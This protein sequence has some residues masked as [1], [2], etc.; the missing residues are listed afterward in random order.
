[1]TTTQGECFV[2]VELVGDERLEGVLGAGE[3][4][5]ARERCMHRAELAATGHRGELLPRQGGVLAARFP[6]CERA[7]LGA[8]EMIARVAALPPQGGANLSLRC[9]LAMEG[10]DSAE[11]E[12]VARG[13][14]A[15]SVP[16]QLLAS[17]GVVACLGGLARLGAGCG[18]ARDLTV[19]A[20][21]V[22]GHVLSAVP[23]APV[24]GVAK[25]AQTQQ[26]LRLRHGE[27]EF[28]MRADQPGVIL[29]RDVGCSLMVDDKRASRQHA[30]IVYRAGVFV[31]V[32]QSTNG[33]S[34]SLAGQ[35]EVWLRYGESELHGMGRIGCGFTTK[36]PANEAK[37]VFFEFL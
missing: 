16:K 11:G 7:V 34:L 31:L 13:L 20:R 15:Q 2:V 22:E 12:A 36:D 28:E 8:F 33:T 32:D 35:D 26:V 27:R 9:G 17:S 3:A 23:Q 19:G 30:K 6:D 18:P 25:P 10:D 21:R 37:L 24:E 14:A 1:M 29:G 5:R 4:G